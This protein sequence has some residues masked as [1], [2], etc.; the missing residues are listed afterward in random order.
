MTVDA[1]REGIAPEAEERRQAIE[2]ELP[3]Y[4]HLDT[5][6]LVRLWGVF[7]GKKQ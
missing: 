7:R 3:T 6:A 1:F 4:C 2:R 5:L